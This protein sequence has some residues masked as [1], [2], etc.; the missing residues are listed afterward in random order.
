MVILVDHPA[1]DTCAGFETD[2]LSGF[3][4]SRAAGRWAVS[5]AREELHLVQAHEALMRHTMLAAS[6]VTS[7]PPA[8]SE[9]TP[10]GRP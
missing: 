3:V 5:S 4:L 9:M 7:R 10:T 8:L 2:V 6:S 1:E